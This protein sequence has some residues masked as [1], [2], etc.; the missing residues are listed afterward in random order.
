MHYGFQVLYIYIY[1]DDSIIKP[2]DKGSGIV[3]W[4]K[5][6][7]LRSERMFKPT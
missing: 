1:N 4:D 5:E 2:A 7:Y 3:M 6:D